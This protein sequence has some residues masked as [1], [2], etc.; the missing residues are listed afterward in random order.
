[1]HSVNKV[2]EN[3]EKAT[4]ECAKKLFNENSTS[5]VKYHEVDSYQHLLEI[6]S[7]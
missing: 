3:I 7:K 2:D 1:M 5:N 4:I 6:V